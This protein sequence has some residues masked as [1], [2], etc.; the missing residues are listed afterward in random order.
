MIGDAIINDGPGLLLIVEKFPWANTL[1][2]THGVEAAMDELRPGLP[3]MEI[4]HEIF[5]PATFIEVS[6]ENLTTALLIGAVLVILVLGA[7]LFEWRS[8]LISAVAIPLS[9]VAAGLVLYLCGT[10]IN[11][12]VLAGFVIAL[13]AVVDDAIIDIENIV[14]R[15][16]QHRKEGS[17]KSTATIILE[18]SL[19]SA[20]RHR[21]RHADRRAGRGAGLLHGG[22]VRRILPAAGALLCAGDAGIAWWSP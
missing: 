13:G 22:P 19:E 7:F 20:R 14:R 12:M 1:Q 16:R 8:A 18:A 2:V 6:I 15:L 17:D 11:V 3:G 21:L 9:L 10:T 5:R 4:D